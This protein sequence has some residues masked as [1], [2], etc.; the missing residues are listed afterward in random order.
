MAHKPARSASQC[1]PSGFRS[2]LLRVGLLVIT[3]SVVAQEYPTKPVRFIVPFA[4]GGGN[5]IIARVLGQKLGEGWGQQVVIDNR[6]GAGG[7]IAAETTARAA[8]DG[9]TVFQFN[10][11]NAIAVSV[12]SRLAYDP[13]RDFAAIT[14]LASSP[15]LLVVNPA[16][17][18]GSVKDFVALAKSQPGKF[19]YASS[20]NG[21]STHLITEMFKTLA[22]IEMTH[23]PYNGAGPGL[24]D[25]LGGQVQMMFAVPA[26]A[27]P[28]L[29]SGKLRALGV[30]SPKR[31]PLAPE[32]PTVAESGVPGF[33]GAT[34]Y[35]VVVPAQTPAP[36]VARLHRDIAHVLR[37]PEV[38]DRLAAQ[39]V[40]LVGSTP[41]EFAQF[42]RSEIPKW[43]RAARISGARVD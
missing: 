4:P 33:E 21:G 10:V 38:Q 20:G 43:A 15:F 28:Y 16:V 29:K 9:H 12:Y 23:V 27:T 24:I 36:I 42:I 13:V 14:Q 7:N 26:T 32:L 6:P 31:S 18:A 30:S 3:S 41:A 2:A 11:A 34:W 1:A 35:G 17:R 22:G 5:D 37:T 40:E 8:P 25:L 19:N 39:G